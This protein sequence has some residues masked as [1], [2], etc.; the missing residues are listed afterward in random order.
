MHLCNIILH[1]E[2][3]LF[4]WILFINLLYIQYHLPVLNK[5]SHSFKPHHS[6]EVISPTPENQKTS[7]YFFQIKYKYNTNTFKIQK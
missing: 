2:L 7:F 3:V 5:D 6:V 1:G 4:T